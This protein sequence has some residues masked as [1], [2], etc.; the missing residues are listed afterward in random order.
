[1]PEIRNYKT[2]DGEVPFD[3]W[4]NDLDSIA[5]AKITTA[6][7]RM[8][9]GNLGDHK[10]VGKGVTERRIDFGPGFRVYFGRDGDEII[11][12]L[13]GGTKKR[14][15]KDIETAQAYWADFK[16]RKKLEARVATTPEVKKQKKRR[17][18]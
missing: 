2:G 10:S 13:L 16:K 1:M 11:L 8:Q 3:H 6:V 5:A 4:F 18:K 9:S 7:L 15:Q 17:R 14:Q 12:L